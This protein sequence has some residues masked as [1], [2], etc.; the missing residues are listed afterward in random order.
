M[1]SPDA[2]Q[3]R[4]SARRAGRWNGVRAEVCEGLRLTDVLPGPCLAGESGLRP[5]PL[6]TAVP[7]IDSEEVP[8]NP[9]R[10]QQPNEHQQ[11]HYSFS[12]T[13]ARLAW[14]RPL[15]NID[16]DGSHSGHDLNLC[17]RVDWRIPGTVYRGSQ[18]RAVHLRAG[19]ARKARLRRRVLWA[20]RSGPARMPANRSSSMPGADG[21]GGPACPFVMAAVSRGK[22]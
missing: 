15:S 13:V 10:R 11:L 20:T 5:I 19:S 7:R 18:M 16:P 22:R 17:R 4:I 8:E 12:I 1:G 9:E 2:V 14:R 3:L 21:S 6:A